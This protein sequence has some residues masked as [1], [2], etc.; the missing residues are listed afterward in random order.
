MTPQTEQDPQQNPTPGADATATQQVK[1]QG[2]QQPS[3]CRM[4][5][6]RDIAQSDNQWPGIVQSVNADGSIDIAVFRGVHF[7]QHRGVTEGAGPG[8]WSWPARA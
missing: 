1:Q 3:I 7:V 4:I 5:V 2:A 6:F 8:Q